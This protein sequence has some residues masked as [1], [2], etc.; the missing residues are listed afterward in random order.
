MSQSSSYRVLP[1]RLGQLVRHL[2]VKP[3][4]GQDSLPKDRT[5]FVTGLPFQLEEGSLLELCSNFGNVERA[6]VYASKG[7]A[8]VL[9]TTPA[10]RDNALQAA[11]KGLIQQVQLPEP[12]APFGLKAWV[13]QHK[14]LTPGNSELQKAL[15]AW[16]E[17]FEAEE[18]RRRQEALRAMEDEGWTVVQRHKGRKKNAGASGV[19]VAGVAG[20]AAQAQA[21]AKKDQ[22]HSDFYRFQ[23]REKRRS[24]LLDLRQRFEDDKRRIAELK[25]ARR[26]KPY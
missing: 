11:A 12:S 19:T 10:G 22:V 18:E 23:Q 17:E 9:Y 15:D 21:A 6:A 5:L 25:A 2:F 1:I 3:H 14:A 20:A 4:V 7:S 8:V 26:F 13:E 24:E 16:T